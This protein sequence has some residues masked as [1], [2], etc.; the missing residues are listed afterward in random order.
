MPTR[1]FHVT[2]DD[3]SLIC[4]KKGFGDGDRHRDGMSEQLAKGFGVCDSGK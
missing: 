3:L 1:T 4:S 2:S